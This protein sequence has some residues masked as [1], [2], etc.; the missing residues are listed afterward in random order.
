L[1]Y[2]PSMPLTK[3]KVSI[4]LDEDLVEELEREE[5]GLSAQVNMAVRAELER[6]RRNRLL[7]ELLAGLDAKYGPVDESLIEKYVGLLT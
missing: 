6:R 3:R 5:E 2:A 1:W 4:S 7:T